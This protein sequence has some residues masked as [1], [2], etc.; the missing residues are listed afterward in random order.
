MNT[1][2]FSPE[3]HHRLPRRSRKKTRRVQGSECRVQDSGCRVQGSGCRVQGSGFMVQGF[4][5]WVI[6]DDELRVR[7][8]RLTTSEQREDIW[9]G[10]ND[11]LLKAKAIIR[12]GPSCFCR[13]RQ[14]AVTSEAPRHATRVNFVVASIYG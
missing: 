9:K 3:E 10:F 1:I 12:P 5:R 6:F 11:C 14:A 4:G 7:V 13:I 8:C 2:G